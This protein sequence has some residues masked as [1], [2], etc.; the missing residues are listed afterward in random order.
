MSKQIRTVF[1]LGSGMKSR[2]L[3]KIDSKIMRDSEGQKICRKYKLYVDF[4]QL[5]G[6]Y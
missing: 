6:V 1:V 5:G 2:E 3:K 4:W